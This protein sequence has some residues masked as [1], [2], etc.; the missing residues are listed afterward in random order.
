M[1]LGV[2]DAKGVFGTTIGLRDE[3]GASRVFDIPLSENAMT[4]VALGMAMTGLRP[5]FTH[6]RADFTFT[7]AEQ[8]INQVAKTIYM[9]AGQYEVPL[10]FRM[11]V[12]RGWGQGPTHAQAPHGLYASIPGLKVL[13]PSNPQDMYS[14]MRAA[15]DDPNPVIVI[16][17]RWLHDLTLDTELMPH[18][19]EGY[20]SK[21]VRAGNDLT[22]AGLSYGFVEAAKITAVLDTFGI[23]VELLDLRAVSPIDTETIVESA[24]KTQNFAMVDIAAPNYGFG[25]EIGRLLTQSTWGTLKRPA[26]LLG[27]RFAPV[28][29][30]PQLALHHYPSLENLTRSIVEHFELGIDETQIETVC[31]YLYTPRNNLRDQPDLCQI[32]P[33]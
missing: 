32:G 11:I 18:V 1:G 24:L 5:V 6:Q 19:G 3:F 26:L 28:P 27:P 29:S 31:R 9:T 25:A 8:L 22:I 14:L 33:F 15:I 16:E 20:R 2:A 17:H 30:S 4:G 7:S 12:G 21:V 23:Q 10:V 13:A